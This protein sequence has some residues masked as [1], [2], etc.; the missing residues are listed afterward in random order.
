MKINFFL[1]FISFLLFIDSN[2]YAQESI[3]IKI[4]DSL[5]NE[6]LVG[7]S[8]KN[9]NNFLSYSTNIDGLC[10]IPIKNN[11]SL[12]LQISYLGFDPKNLAIASEFKGVLEVKLHVSTKLS[13]EIIIN[14]TRAN[15]NSASTFSTLTSKDIEKINLGKDIPVLLNSIP[16]TVV[17]S[18]AGA[19]VGYTGIRIRGTDP[20]RINTTINGIPVNDSES[21]ATF[22]V[23]MP[24]F[25]SSVNDIQIQRGVGTSTNGS[26]AFGA[27]INMQTT[28]YN[29]E[30]Y[31]SASVSGG[32]FNTIR[33]NLKLGSGLLFNKFTVDAR[34]SKITSDGFINRASSNLGSYY[35]GANYY[36]KNNSLKLIHFAGSEVTY[37][38]WNGIPESRYN[39]D[40]EGMKDFALRNYLNQRD[41]LN[42]FNSNSKTYNVFTYKNQVDNYKQ[43]HYQAHYTH[44]LSSYLN[45]N[46]SLHY[47]KGQ[48]YYE[49][50]KD[51]QLLS[52]YF[53][54]PKVNG[55]DT[56]LYSDLVRRKWLDNDFYGTTFSLQYNKPQKLNSIFGGS[57]NQYYGRHFG[58]VISTKEELAFDPDKNYYHNNSLKSEYSFFLK[59]TFYLSST[60]SV[61]A[62]IQ[63]RNISYSFLG[64][65]KSFLT[66][67]DHVAYHFINPKLGLNYQI[68]NLSVVY[69]SCAVAHREP[70]REDFVSSSIQSRPQQER[71]ID[72]ELGYGIRESKFVFNAV[73]FL[74]EYKNQMVLSGKLNDV[75]AYT[76]INVPKSY[77]RGIELEGTYFLNKYCS[78][79]SNLAFSKN[80]IL[81]YSEFVDNYDLGGQDEIKIGQSKIAFSPQFIGCGILELNPSK[82]LKIL[83]QHKYVDKQFLD[84]SMDNGRMLKAFYVS[85]INFVFT[86]KTKLFKSISF[87][88]GLYNIFNKSYVPNGY[89]Y[90]YIYGG[91]RT[92]E[93]FYYPMAGINFLLGLNIKI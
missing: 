67:Q 19:G 25:I 9:T 50:Y 48:G 24:D 68:N 57:I 80:V 82:S 65:N 13:D 70:T 53:I 30:P 49:E 63:T 43:K 6:A 4:I 1:V 17:N 52:N 15:K 59:N 33:T 36:G 81:N 10:Q 2:I 85:D 90:G 31:A 61:L 40:L 23:N 69:A 78:I 38:A 28:Q 20:T 79:I 14:A 87:N 22:F 44:K 32:S 89:T 39:G 84:N 77:R 73:A 55:N 34:A 16:N 83:W 56:L 60:F 66:Q 54:E 18:D 75:G 72:T 35:V 42:L 76:R 58:R 64:I 8:I 5:S 88:G 11:D 92:T 91:K 62:D 37:Q 47:T 7:A 12:F 93:N 86:P 74:M 21:Q 46:I 26:A 51:S 27:S 41:S 71:L 29:P 3:K 45:A